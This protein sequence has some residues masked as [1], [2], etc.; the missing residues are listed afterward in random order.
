MEYKYKVHF[1]DDNGNITHTKQYA[2][3]TCIKNALNISFASVKM[4]KS[5]SEG[6]FVPKI[7][8]KKNTLHKLAKKY[9][10]ISF[11]YILKELLDELAKKYDM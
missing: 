11:N 10:I 4:I 8:D 7:Q 9:K 1:L 2:N 5:H 6:H 3:M